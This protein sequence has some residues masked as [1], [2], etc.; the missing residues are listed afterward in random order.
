MVIEVADKLTSASAAVA[1][2]WSLTTASCY[3]REVKQL[4]LKMYVNG[5]GFRAIERV[6][7]INH[8]TIINAGFASC[9]KFAPSS[10]RLQN[11]SNYRD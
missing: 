10:P 9:S 11:S 2:F 4:C 5:M 6:I 7:G 1:N 8:N 3:S